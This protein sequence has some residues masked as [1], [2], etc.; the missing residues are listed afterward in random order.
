MPG[1]VRADLAGVAEAASAAL[2]LFLRTIPMVVAAVGA[3]IA[4]AAAVRECTP[5][6]T[7]GA[8]AG[9]A[10]CMRDCTI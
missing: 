9:A 3:G 4:G 1:A 10:P 6:N 5:A 7:A 2:V 8:E